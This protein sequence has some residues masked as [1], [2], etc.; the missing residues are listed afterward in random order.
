MTPTIQQEMIIQNHRKISVPIFIAN[1]D[2]HDAILD[3]LW[4]NGNKFLL[5]MNI[6]T[7]DF[8]M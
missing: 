3:K 8:P 1:L 6:D 7:I 5:Y 4:T 2:Q